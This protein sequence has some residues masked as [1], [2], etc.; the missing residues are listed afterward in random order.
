MTPSDSVALIAASAAE[1]IPYFKGKIKGV[2][3]SMPTSAALDRCLVCMGVADQYCA[4]CQP[5]C[6]MAFLF[7]RV[8]E[9]KGIT[10][11]EVPTGW[12][13]FGN[14]M[15]DGRCSICGEESF[16]TGSDHIRRAATALIVAHNLKPHRHNPNAGT[17]PTLTCC[18]VSHREKD[19]L[20]AVLAWLSILAHVNGARAKGLLQKVS[21]A[22]PGALVPFRI[23]LIGCKPSRCRR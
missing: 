22:A 1:S 16:G 12:K 18:S 7:H 5:K 11:Y 2:A 4:L 3:R 15:D 13:F 14:L 20:W 8:A 23:L 21:Q 17:S 10:C 6:S 9:K 19:G